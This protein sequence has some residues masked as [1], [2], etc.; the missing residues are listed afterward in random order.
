VLEEPSDFTRQQLRLGEAGEVTFWE[1][2]LFV[3]GEPA[4]LTQEWCAAADVLNEAHAQLSK[5]I[6]DGEAG[7]D[8]MLAVLLGQPGIDRLAA[9]TTVSATV[10]GEERG[11]LLPVPADSPLLQLRQRV[12]SED[13]VPLLLAK[14]LLAPGTP[15]LTITQLT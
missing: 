5:R 1:S 6:A 2:V 9:E 7:R 15:P 4:C 13:E 3:D 8:T 14:H 12:L 11:E 10:I